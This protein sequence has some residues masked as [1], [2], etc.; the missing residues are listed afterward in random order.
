MKSQRAV[1]ASNGFAV[2]LEDA[3]VAGISKRGVEILPC[4]AEGR[5][6]KRR[7]RT[8]VSITV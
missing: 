8:C 1:A 7:R 2:H 6:T 4:P 5:K 3:P